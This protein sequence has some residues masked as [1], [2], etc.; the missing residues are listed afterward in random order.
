MPR[1]HHV[2][3]ALVLL[4]AT[5]LRFTG[6]DWGLRHEPHEDERLFVDAVEQMLV[7]RDLDHRFYQ[8]PGLMFYLLAPVLAL[9]DPPPFGPRAFLAARALIAACG[10]LAVFLAWRLGR[11]LGGESAGLFAA[12]LLAVSPA[13][14]HTAHM[15]RPDVPL[16]VLGLLALLA[17][18]R[19]GERLRDDARAGFWLGAA[20]AL[21]FSAVFLGPAYLVVRG[22][23]PG[24]RLRGIAV[25]VLAAGVA[26]VALSPYA[27][28]HAFEFVAGARDQVVHHY[29]G[30][31]T[32][33]SSL[34]Y[35]LGHLGRSLGPPGVA[36]VAFGAFR[37]RR[38]P[39]VL[40]VLAQLVV[41][42][43]V[44]S[45]ADTRFLR[46]LVP[47]M[48]GLAVVAGL[49]YAALSPRLSR[50]APALALLAAI[51]PLAVSADY[52]HDVARPSTW[53]RAADWAAGRFPHGASI[54]TNL[55]LGLDP[56][57]FEVVHPSGEIELD[58]LLA[59]EVDLVIWAESPGPRMTSGLDLLFLAE[60]LGPANGHPLVLAAA[61]A[62]LRPRYQR[63]DLQAAWL[64]SSEPGLD[65]APLLDGD[66]ASRVRIPA[67]ERP[68]FV[69]VAFPAPQ[70][71]ARVEL[72]LGPR[73]RGRREGVELLL[74]H[75]LQGWERAPHVEAR[76][77]P[78]RQA[79]DRAAS[80]VL[81][82]APA[83]AVGVRV[84]YRG[85]R[86]WAP[87]SLDVDVVPQP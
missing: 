63:L 59:R 24:P 19:I 38:D 48:G 4:L 55:P 46:H 42:L 68:R 45:T 8:Y 34:L 50:F 7:N 74:R 81:L 85:R 35:Y 47:A 25:A 17:M 61:P 70:R 69:E 71:V 31:E 5:G 54:L 72:G 23:K 16:Q 18:G 51:P 53:D 80:Q 64:R 14:V 32:P 73:G 49:G 67:A 11:R 1:L 58:R 76:P 52:V 79:G 77:H 27:V 86:A 57:R 15:L 9:F 29:Q 43:A 62:E 75:P 6:L 3:L 20:F 78:T 87:S 21:K 37:H 41:T 39:L 65:L 56:A 66:A 2:L 60:P 26:F 40:A 84:V 13:D 36:L 30:D 12:L 82:I 10:V 44:M 28:L 22:L 33:A 83:E